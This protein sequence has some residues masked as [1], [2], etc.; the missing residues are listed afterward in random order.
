MRDALGYS[1]R[2]LSNGEA[3]SSYFPY[4]VAD[5][6][7]TEMNSFMML[8]TD[9][10]IPIKLL[11]SVAA[12]KTFKKGNPLF[13]MRS[14]RSAL[15][16]VS[17]AAADN[18]LYS[19]MMSHILHKLGF[20]NDE[21]TIL[22][23]KRSLQLFASKK[24]ILREA[25]RASIES[26][27]DNWFEPL[28]SVPTQMNAAILGPKIA[29]CME[30]VRKSWRLAQVNVDY[31]ERALELTTSFAHNRNLGRLA[32][33]EAGLLE[34]LSYGNILLEALSDDARLAAEIDGVVS[35]LPFADENAISKAL[36]LFARVDGK[37][38]TV[39]NEDVCDWFSVLPLSTERTNELKMIAI[40]PAL[41]TPTFDGKLY[42]KMSF[43]MLFPGTLKIEEAGFGI[44]KTAASRLSASGAACATV[45]NE[46]SLEEHIRQSFELLISELA[47]SSQ[48]I[49]IKTVGFNE[50]KGRNE[51][52]Q[53]A[54]INGHEVPISLLA[55]YLSYTNNVNCGS[56]EV[57]FM[58]SPLPQSY[59]VLAALPTSI[60]LADTMLISTHPKWMLLGAPEK[61]GTKQPFGVTSLSTLIGSSAYVQMRELGTPKS[62]G[63]VKLSATF[64][65]T[66]DVG[67]EVDAAGETSLS[68]V[69]S[70][71]SEVEAFMFHDMMNTRHFCVVADHI[72]LLLESDLSEAIK[73]RMSLLPL[74]ALLAVSKTEVVQRAAAQVM[75]GSEF[76]RP[77]Q[78]RLTHEAA[79]AVLQLGLA[80]SLIGEM[81]GTTDLWR[82]LLSRREDVLAMV[83]AN[84]GR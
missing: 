52:S 65:F 47:P 78:R 25:T 64:T 61:K 74:S 12:L 22:F 72:N 11:Q 57:E 49:D 79:R 35:Y 19:V 46:V 28:G 34:L 16:A 8:A 36:D 39:S 37:I 70:I 13:S 33:Q 6:T 48:F 75:K 67:Q 38:T 55:L 69:L 73:T 1:A 77:S 60:T 17:Q 54:S 44:L 51:I 66:N 71:P 14:Y 24:D 10:E 20:I 84:L 56:G 23:P 45:L 15:K 29:E 5:M 2:A 40:T 82:K 53:T 18:E 80:A 68:E 4:V 26:T 76:S 41:K 43:D 27:M 63:N 30:R 31:L 81:T 83:Y 42:D 59:P 32:E 21:I 50:F 7:S 58:K 3:V 62:I 9:Y